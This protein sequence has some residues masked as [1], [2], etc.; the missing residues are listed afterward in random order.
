MPNHSFESSQSAIHALPSPEAREWDSARAPQMRAPVR[1]ESTCMFDE[2]NLP[3]DTAAKSMA[4]LFREAY[5]EK[6]PDECF[7]DPLQIREV[8]RSGKYRF[9]AALDQAGQTLGIGGI[10]KFEYLG[11]NVEHFGSVCEFGKLIVAKRAQGMGLAGVLTKMRIEYVEQMGYSSVVSLPF[12]SHDFSQRSL[13][14]AGFERGGISFC[15]WD[16]VFGIGQRESALFMHKIVDPE[17]R[18]A[19]QVF[20][21]SALHHVASIA[22]ESLKCE[23]TFDSSTVGTA[24][25]QPHE[26]RADEL[27]GALQ[28]FLHCPSSVEAMLSEVAVKAREMSDLK[29]IAVSMDIGNPLAVP[30]I[31]RLLNDGFRFSGLHPFAKSD[32]LT[33]QKVFDLPENFMTKLKLFDEDGALVRMINKIID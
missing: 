9:S 30:T 13:T 23:R 17:I 19:R 22:Y 29:H 8:I 15:D 21:P 24:S 18:N 16:D 25:G 26:I 12:G 5:G 20:L 31:E 10:S 6:Y 14:K 2:R 7:L 11:A 33:M 28:I 32:L 3:N 27:S 1:V 4:G